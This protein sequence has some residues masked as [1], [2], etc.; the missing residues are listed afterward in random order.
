MAYQ[1]NLLWV[2]KVL[3]ADE[4]KITLWA[5]GFSIRRERHFLLHLFHRLSIRSNTISRT[6]RGI[7]LPPMKVLKTTLDIGKRQFV[8]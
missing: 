1:Q 3:S 4:N 5:V 8:S 7:T 6:S 2:T